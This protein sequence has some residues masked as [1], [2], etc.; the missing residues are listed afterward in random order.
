MLL[1]A[2][3][4]VS[5]PTRRSLFVSKRP[6]AGVEI[7]KPAEKVTE[8]ARVQ[9]KGKKRHALTGRVGR[10]TSEHRASIVKG[11]R[12]SALGQKVSQPPSGGW[13][14]CPAETEAEVEMASAFVMRELWQEQQALEGE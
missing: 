4:S 7:I 6:G 8:S 2:R 10:T 13:T 5:E 1:R 3:L 11:V 12:G 9:Y 14:I